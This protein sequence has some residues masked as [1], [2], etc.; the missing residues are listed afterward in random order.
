VIADI[1][2]G[3]MSGLELLAIVTRTPGAL[4]VILI[5]GFDGGVTEAEAIR[6]GAFAYIRK[7]F[8]V[9]E[10][11]QCAT[12]ALEHATALAPDLPADATLPRA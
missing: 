1:H 3:R 5:T 11:L 9:A 7:P 6:L 8:D 12:R 2:L 10:L 4:P